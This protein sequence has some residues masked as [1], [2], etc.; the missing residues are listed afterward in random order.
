MQRMD[1]Y[2]ALVTQPLSRVNAQSGLALICVP[3]VPV[4]NPENYRVCRSQ[5]ADFAQVPVRRESADSSAEVAGNPFTKA[6]SLTGFFSGN[7]NAFHGTGTGPI[8][9]ACEDDT[10]VARENTVSTGT[11]GTQIKPTPRLSL[12]AKCPGPVR[13][14]AWSF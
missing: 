2:V 14:D 7:F 13:I 3:R 10:R 5:P 11:L 8:S 1:F 9:T 6:A 4:G 12:R